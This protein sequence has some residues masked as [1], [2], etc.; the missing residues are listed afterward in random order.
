M[1]ACASGALA[2]YQSCL[3]PV[4]GAVVGRLFAGIIALAAPLILSNCAVGPDFAHPA[5]PEIARYTR[6]PLSP[7][8]GSPTEAGGRQ[9]FREGGDISG[10][11]WQVFKSRD[12]DA[13]IEHALIANPTLQAALATLR[14]AKEDVYAQQAK[15]LPVVQANLNPTRQRTSAALAPVP[16]S[17][18]SIFSLETA[19]LTVAYTFDVWGQNRRAVESLEALADVQRFEVEAAYLALTS[20]L[21][22]A[23]VTEASLREQIEA[24]SRLIAV[25]AKMRDTMRRQLDAGYANRNDLAAQEAALAQ[26]E[27]TLP[28]LRK[29]LAQQHDL[30]AALAGGFPSDSPRFAF[31]L[32]ELHLPLDLPVSV[33]SKL[34]EQRPDVRAAEEQLHSAS[35]QIG[36]ATANL[37]PNFTISANGGYMNTAFAGLLAPQ[38]LMW[39]LAGNVTQTVFDAGALWHQLQGAKETYHAAAWTYRGAVVGAV[40]NVTDALRAVQNDADALRAALDFERAAKTSFTLAQQQMDVGNANVLLFLTAE[41]AYLQATLQVIAARAA[42][43]A[44]TAALF[45]ALGGGW[46]NRPDAP[47]ESRLDVATGEAAPAP[48]P[49]G[50]LGR[51]VCLYCQ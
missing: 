15:F 36:V 48:P 50:Y 46:W 32:A 30:I 4:S 10:A 26:A 8:T 9:V 12:L 14:A 7:T 33:P 5:A 23:V 47:P 38:N 22:V 21:V 37:L 29:A 41:Q 13:L 43:L 24:T 42:R 27:A 51:P 11:W 40:Q 18:A 31:H 28:P 45:A 3:I 34:I 39:L 44:D 19:Q 17:G 16:S 25:A 6:E 35:A 2:R 20:N 1:P 49:E